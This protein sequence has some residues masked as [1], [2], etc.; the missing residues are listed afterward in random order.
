MNWLQIAY[1]RGRREYIDVYGDF[2][3]M[4]VQDVLDKINNRSLNKISFFEKYFT[5]RNHHRFLDSDKCKQFLELYD[6]KTDA[7]ESIN[8]LPRTMLIRDIPGIDPRNT[9]EYIWFNLDRNR[10]LRY[11]TDLQMAQK[12]RSLAVASMLPQ[13]VQENIMSQLDVDTVGEIGSRMEPS[14]RIIQ[15]PGLG[16]APLE[17][18]DYDMDQTYDEFVEQR[19]RRKQ[20]RKQREQ[21]QR[22]RDEDFENFRTYLYLKDL[23][24]YG[25]IKNKQKGG[26][27]QCEKYQQC[28][29]NCRREYE[30]TK[31]LPPKTKILSKKTKK[32]PKKSEM[33]IRSYIM[34]QEPHIYKARVL[35]R[36]VEN[37]EHNKQYAEEIINETTERRSENFLSVLKEII[38]EMSEEELD[39]IR[40]K[41]DQYNKERFPNGLDQYGL[42]QYGGMLDDLPI[43]VIDE[44]LEKMNCRDRLSYCQTNRKSRDHCNSKRTF[45]KYI[46]PCRKKSKM[47]K[48]KRRAIE[49]SKRLQ[50]KNHLENKIKSMQDEMRRKEEMEERE[51][52]ERLRQ[53]REIEIRR[54]IN[55][56]FD[57][58]DDELNGFPPHY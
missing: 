10:C 36:V 3:T 35:D 30:L 37:K 33:T 44:Q 52:L 42:D 25:G 20:L 6:N 14:G 8:P 28:I 51:L 57:F 15:R 56:D 55:E 17:L 5:L 47:N 23:D 7:I 40:E 43:E 18:Q 29:D 26:D 53:P 21:L 24:Q 54:N 31:I 19:R 41:V 27:F 12:R 50:K 11:L 22:E 34:T 32:R 48:T 58:D 39:E 2:Q 16:K 4:T 1:P 46:E 45:K 38:S 49:V 9:K 13:N